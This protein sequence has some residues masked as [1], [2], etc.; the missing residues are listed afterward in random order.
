MKISKKE[1][2]IDEDTGATIWAITP[3]EPDR[4][5]KFF[6]VVVHPVKVHG[7][8]IADEFNL[9]IPAATIQEAFAVFP[10]I[11]AQACQARTEMV[12]G[13]VEQQLLDQQMRLAIPGAMKLPTSGKAYD[14]RAVSW[15]RE[16]LRDTIR[17]HDRRG[18]LGRIG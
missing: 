3:V 10:T 13:E 6:A 1:I 14:R 18:P 9:E 4:E 12:R 15:R 7:K 5:T 11:V 8:Q 2:Y 17:H 16:I